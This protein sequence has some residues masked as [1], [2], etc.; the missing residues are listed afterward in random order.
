[1]L[2]KWVELV[3]GGSISRGPFPIRVTAGTPAYIFVTDMVKKHPFYPV[4][5]MGVAVHTLEERTVDVGL[6]VSEGFAGKGDSSFE[7]I[8]LIVQRPPSE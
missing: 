1:V 3:E 4:S 7:P 6:P 5:Y 8:R 2:E